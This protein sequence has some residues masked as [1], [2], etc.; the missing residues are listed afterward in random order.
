MG[1]VV[2]GRVLEFFGRAA[3]KEKNAD[4]QQR[5]NRQLAQLCHRYRRHSFPD[6]RAEEV[7]SIT[8]TDTSWGQ[9]MQAVVTMNG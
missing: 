5:L 2:T 9:G 6:V 4:H 8:D 3:G 7:A 1:Q